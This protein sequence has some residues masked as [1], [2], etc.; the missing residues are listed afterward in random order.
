[1]GRVDARVM[2]WLLGGDVAIQYQTQRDLKG[3]ER[4]DLRGRIELEG[5]GARFLQLRRED[6]HW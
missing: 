6:G 5:W 3:S 1:M 4:E 2:D